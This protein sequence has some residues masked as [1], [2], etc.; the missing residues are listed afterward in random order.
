MKK[1]TNYD[2]KEQMSYQDP[3]TQ[4]DLMVT[5]GL[6]H[7]LR[8]NGYNKLRVIWI[9]EVISQRTVAK[10]IKALNFWNDGSKLP[11]YIYISSLGGECSVGF[12]LIDFIEALKKNGVPVYTI[13]YGEIASMASVIYMTG[14]DGCR[15]SMPNARFMFHGSRVS[16]ATDL[17]VET[18]EFLKN[19]LKRIN[20]HMKKYLVDKINIKKSKSK[21]KSKSKNFKTIDKK[22]LIKLM[23]SEDI[24][25]SAKE[26][27]NLGIVDS[28]SSFT[29]NDILLRNMPN[30]D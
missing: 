12:A 29:I 14:T 21:S 9:D 11:V 30:Q 20:N 16:Y 28:V 1:N 13:A 3:I 27:E 22:E 19:E 17:T 8:D 10:H 26:L 6:Y 2:N 7:N 24:Y 25:F 18:A 4:K 5:P 15:I 23:I